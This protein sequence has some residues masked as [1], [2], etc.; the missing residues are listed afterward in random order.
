MQTEEIQQLIE[1]G[2]NTEIVRVKGDGKHFTA[3][4]VSPEFS[5]KNRLD[6]QRLVFATLKEVLADQR[7]HAI[8]LKTFTPDEWHVQDKEQE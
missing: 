6:R 7:L 2:M 8:T 4:I 5:N 1:A 3:V